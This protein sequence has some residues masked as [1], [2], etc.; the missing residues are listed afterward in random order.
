[1]VARHHLAGRPGLAL[2][3]QDEVLDDVEQPVV[4]QHAVEQDFGIHPALFVF[5][6]ASIRQNAP[7]RW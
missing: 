1:M 3:E 5:L 7:T 6:A 4:R 2:V